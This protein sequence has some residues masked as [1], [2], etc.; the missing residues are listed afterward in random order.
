M[1]LFL[2]TTIA[3]AFQVTLAD[4]RGDSRAFGAK[5][6]KTRKSQ[7]GV[8][9]AKS[10][11]SASQTSST[12][13]GMTPF[14]DDDSL[15]IDEGRPPKNS[16]DGGLVVVDGTEGADGSEEGDDLLWNDTFDDDYSP[17]SG[18]GF[19]PTDAMF[20]WLTMCAA[21]DLDKDTC[22]VAKTLDYLVEY[23]PGDDY[24]THPSKRFRALEQEEGC[25]PE[26]SQQDLRYV[27]DGA[28][29]DCSRFSAVY[30]DE[31]F[32]ILFYE[33]WTVLSSESCWNELC[34][35]PD[36]FF[37][38]M[39][40]HAVQCANVDFDVDQCIT[41]HIFSTLFTEPAFDDDDDYYDY[42]GTDDGLHALRSLQ[43]AV[44]GDT[45]ADCV[46]VNESDLAFVASFVLMDARGRCAEKGVSVTWEDISKASAD[47][48]M[49]FSSPHCWGDAH[50]CPEDDASHAEDDFGVFGPSDDSLGFGNVTWL[51]N[52][53]QPVGSTPAN[54]ALVDAL[55]ND[56]YPYEADEEFNSNVT[57]VDEE[58]DVNE[59]LSS[60]NS[61]TAESLDDD[62]EP[63]MEDD[64]FLIISE[65]DDIAYVNLTYIEDINATSI[66]DDDD[67][68]LDEEDVNAT[69]TVDEYDGNTTFAYEDN[70][71][72]STDDD[73]TDGPSI[74]V[75]ESE[76][77]TT[78]ANED[79]LSDTTDDDGKSETSLS[80]SEGEGNGASA[81]EDNSLI[82]GDG[83]GNGTS[84]EDGSPFST[85][86]PVEND[87][88]P[89]LNSSS[90]DNT[91]IPFPSDD[92]GGV[93]NPEVTDGSC[94]VGPRSGISERSIEVPYFYIVETI[95]LEG[96]ADEIEG[97]LHLMMCINGVDR[98]LSVESAETSLVALESAPEDILSTEC[99]FLSCCPLFA[100]VFSFLSHN[101]T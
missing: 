56:G 101:L 83:E 53:T 81:N 86:V 25:R 44:N 12:V 64:T 63:I 61:T 87:T 31:H 66:V 7:H 40:D 95:V 43:E 60:N 4:V 17:S 42:Y 97:M 37:R 33:F 9:D 52:S 49:L 6:S 2:L 58:A 54:E 79:D 1:K 38:L 78:S 72:G 28:R 59:G 70:L 24:T 71:S 62:D 67:F 90:S 30:S 26:L 35:S 16:E 10:S 20:E 55:S 39:F 65:E 91:T 18:E 76:G 57:A 74:N 85:F 29:A 75:S 8:F 41:D 5:A 13:D 15:P 99:K 82:M 3:L 69:S 84:T 23:S 22:L 93:F 34:E 36:I 88:A 47:L 11:K 68:S 80:S 27:M 51:A 96:V 21:A 48:I 100:F 77:N 73:I 46:E 98:R 14:N 45:E 89:V 94:D 50:A 19:D 92:S 32:E